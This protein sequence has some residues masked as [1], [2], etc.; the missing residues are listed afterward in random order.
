MEAYPG[1]LLVGVFPLVFCVDATSTSSAA[2]TTDGSNSKAPE[3]PSHRSQFD[4][5]L[6]AVSMVE[7]GEEHP[8]AVEGSAATSLFRGD[9]DED[10]DDE[11][12]FFMSSPSPSVDSD[13]ILSSTGPGPKGKK[14]RNTSTKRSLNMA[15]FRL[16]GR[17]SSNITVANPTASNIFG[18]SVKETNAIPHPP[19]PMN[20]SYANALQQGQGFF[21][22]ARIVSISTRHGFPPS[23]D[24]TGDESNRIAQFINPK[25]SSI[26][27]TKLLHSLNH[28]PIDGILTSGW[29]EKHAG[30]LP[31]VLMVVV[32]VTGNSDASAATSSD[33]KLLETLESL[34]MQLAPKRECQVHVVGLV[35]EGV[36]M[37]HA[38]QWSQTL[39]EELY[40]QNTHI[41]LLN[42]EY[43]SS[44]EAPSQALQHLHRSVRNASLTYYLNQARRTKSKL[45]QLGH[46]RHSP[47]LLPLAIRY[48]FKVAMFYEFQ[49]KHEKSLK[50]MAEAYRHV[51]QYYRYLLQKREEE[52][53][54]D[55]V[56]P[57]RRK[58]ARDPIR[59]VSGST[60]TTSTSEETETE[61]VELA[62]RTPQ[63]ENAFDEI[64]ERAPPTSPDM[65]HQCRAVADWLN[66]KIL[67]AGF[68]SHT[69]GGLL[70]ASSQWQK[71]A[72]AFTSIRSFITASSDNIWHDWMYV[73]NQRV[74]VSQLLERHPPKA[75]GDLGNEFDEVLLRCSP[76]R[77]YEAAAEALLQLGLH[78]KRAMTS[79]S[80][81]APGGKID[82]LCGRYVGG[83]SNDGLAPILQ[84]EFKK[85]HREKAL[86]C[87]SR[88][89]SLFERDLEK[90]KAKDDEEHV[91]ERSWSRSGARMYYLAG[92]ILS[93]LE[94]HAE[95]IPYLQKAVNYSKGWNGLE[96]VIRRMLIECYEKH[97]PTQSEDAAS[98]SNQIVASMI[99]DSY[100][101]AEMSNSNL[102]KALEKFSTLRAGEIKWYRDCLDE[103]DS[104]LPFSFALTFPSATHATAG[105]AVKAS[106]LIKSNLDYAVH[107][108]SVTL[109]SS[110]G[111]ISIPSGD[112][113]SAKNANEGSDGGIII[114]AHTE[115]LIS[116]QLELPKDLNQIAIDETGNGGEKEGVA[117]KGK[118]ILSCTQT[119]LPNLCVN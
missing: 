33:K 73:A 91:R 114:Q 4:R 84:E 9:E 117:G 79:S 116:T 110:A 60:T 81:P 104:S 30:A 90:A 66:F 11:D 19:P 92:G 29:L 72:Q 7:E 55:P 61:G 10:S 20:T 51:E 21:Q 113:L 118:S 57:S 62:L 112:L 44:E 58:P 38:E 39:S 68:V 3:S 87:V 119:A 8:L 36:S 99:L 16:G 59:I 13:D 97:I 34:Q 102:R 50:F 27:P 17:N 2:S 48:C 67:H 31:S 100:F 63:K 85:N 80:S 75:L 5:F 12:E 46:A 15:N 83:L 86:D 22:R 64:A 23:K 40:G 35:Q 43:L 111:K 47:L 96:L 45:A 53:S 101:N 14:Q 65:L 115:I 78:V 56:S 74:V 76:W 107:I 41:T 70:A 1:E 25:T 94:R 82:D 52:L 89:I 95:A 54:D 88:A 103:A 18:G 37:I 26:E 77:T 106:V 49:W 6:D 93:G 98:E 32:A 42:V 108:N 69:E 71:H 24:S 28:R 109:L 105:D